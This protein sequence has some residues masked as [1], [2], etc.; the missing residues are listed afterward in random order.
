MAQWTEVQN[1]TPK[2][3]KRFTGIKRTT[4]D[5]LVGI[6]EEEAATHTQGG[7]PHR[8]GLHDRLLMTLMYW[9]E[10]RTLYHIAVE[11]GWDE[12][13]VRKNILGIEEKLL[14]S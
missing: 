13:N 2:D 1:L 12:S 11:F 6:L 8:F 3:F 14:I 10:A 9:R 7:R 4:F 5:Q